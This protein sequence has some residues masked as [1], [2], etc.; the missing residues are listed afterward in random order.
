MVQTDA[1]GRGR[2]QE[3]KAGLNLIG[4]RIL[5]VCERSERVTDQCIELR[6]GGGSQEA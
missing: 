2:S 3:V 5:E 1:F 4:T 6:G